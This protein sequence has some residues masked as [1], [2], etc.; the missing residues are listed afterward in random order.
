[1]WKRSVILLT[2]AGPFGVGACAGGD[3]GVVPTSTGPQPASSSIST[4][5]P[6]SGGQAAVGLFR[7]CHKRRDTSIV[8]VLLFEN[9]DR[10]LLGGFQGALDFKVSP[11]DPTTW[12]A[13]GG[14][15][16][17]D[18]GRNDHVRQITVPPG[19]SAPAEVTLEV[20]TTT[21]ANPTKVLATNHVTIAV[22]ATSCTSA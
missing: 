8:L 7:A 22:P 20:A 1:V 15:V 14:A 10:A 19:Q 9:R 6:G 5:G 18:P 11:V 21:A 16:T 3:G 2:L 4:P 13:T 12:P 17:V